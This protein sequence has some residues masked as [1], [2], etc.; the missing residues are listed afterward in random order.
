MHH[1]IQWMKVGTWCGDDGPPWLSEGETTSNLP[2]MHWK[3]SVCIYIYKCIYIWYICLV[4]D[5]WMLYFPFF[6]EAKFDWQQMT[7]LWWSQDF[8]NHIHTIH[9]W[10]LYLRLPWKSTKCRYYTIQRSFGI[11]QET[12]VFVVCFLPGGSKIRRSW[13]E[14]EYYPGRIK[15]WQWKMTGWWCDIQLLFMYYICSP[16]D[17]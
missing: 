8:T 14:S 5:W 10:Y 7:N 17:Y 4:K 13:D 1:K 15:H 3:S 6:L 9:V 16:L 12:C 2:K 11:V